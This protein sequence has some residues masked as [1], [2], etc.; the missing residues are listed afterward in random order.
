MEKPLEG[1][2]GII[3]IE[4]S[5]QVASICNILT[6]QDYQFRYGEI[7]DKLDNLVRYLESQNSIYRMIENSNN[8]IRYKVE[9]ECHD[10]G[11]ESWHISKNPDIDPDYKEGE[12]C[13]Y[14]D[15]HLG[16][17]RKFLTIAITCGSIE[18]A[19]NLGV[20]IIG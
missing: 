12:V 16:I 20:K 18:E 15:F 8:S 3:L 11:Y 5:K 13:F 10:N 14:E 19:F 2:T 7:R 4:A 9:K 17:K 1:L 6:K